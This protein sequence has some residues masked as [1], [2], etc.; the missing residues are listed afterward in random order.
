MK[1]LVVGGAGYIGGAVT[2]LLQDAGYEVKVY[3]M[4]LYEETYRKPVTFV[5]GD[6]RDSGTL[7]LHLKSADVV[8]WLAALVGDGACGLNPDIATEINQNRVA[9]LAKNFDG[10][11]I[12]LSTC[13]V[14]GAQEFELD[15]SSPT[16]PLSIY[17]A[18]KLAAE[19]Y[20]AEKN[21]IIFRLGTLYGVGDLF[22]RIRLDL[23]VNT[24]VVKAFTLGK[25]TVY[26]GE[27][28]RPLLHAR[29]AAQAIVNNVQ[30]SH[31]GIY[32]LHRQNVRIIDLAFQ[33][34]NHFP[35]IE[36]VRTEMSFQDARNYRVSSQKAISTFGFR[37]KYTVDDGI[38]ELKTLLKEGRIKDIGNARYANHHFLKG[39]FEKLLT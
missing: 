14:Y 2:D 35:D 16:N 6:I 38:E 9:W 12:F 29:D 3:D 23:A 20:L 18:T 4:L 25:I 5:Y 21:A 19:Q 8:I 27:Q 24:L 22:S 34:R 15:E 33:I 10:R 31:C 36:I 37:P 7:L 28:F 30:T 17:A 1:V 32:N 11:I 26:G 13:S 39:S